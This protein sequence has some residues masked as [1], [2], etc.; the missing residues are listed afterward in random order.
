MDQ[1]I[2]WL[3]GSRP[4]KVF[5]ERSQADHPEPDLTFWYIQ[6]VNWISSDIFLKKLNLG[7]TCVPFFPISLLGFVHKLAHKL[8]PDSKFESGMIWEVRHK[9]FR[10]KKIIETVAWAASSRRMCVKYP[11][12][13]NSA[14]ILQNRGQILAVLWNRNYL[15]RFRFRFWLLKSFGSDSGSGSNF[16]KVMVPVPVP[17]FEKVPVPVPVPAPYLDHKKQIFLLFTL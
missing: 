12:G 4:E 16:W 5:S 3:F 6:E 2:S 1:Q 7:I 11:R 17:T 13:S 9:S 15:L 14:R 8:D 10:I